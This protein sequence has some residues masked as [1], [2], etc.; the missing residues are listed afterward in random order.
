VLPGSDGMEVETTY[1]FTTLHPPAGDS[2]R[3][4]GGRRFPPFWG[5]LNSISQAYEEY[6]KR[7]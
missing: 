1:D 4:V 6:V 2:G 5:S 3:Q 7:Y